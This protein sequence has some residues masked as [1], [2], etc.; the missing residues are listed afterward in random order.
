MASAAGPPKI[1]MTSSGGSWL[2]MIGPVP[3]TARR[4]HHRVD[5]C[6]SL[7]CPGVGGGRRVGQLRRDGNERGVGVLRESGEECECLIGGDVVTLHDHSL[8][9]SDDIP[10]LK[11]R[12]EL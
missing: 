2:V 8:G 1:G 12:V 11:S 3:G 7:V 4:D 6:H 9:L 5:D 10:G